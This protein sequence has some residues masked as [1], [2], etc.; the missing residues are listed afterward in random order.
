M[1]SRKKFS[2]GYFLAD[3]SDRGF[4]RGIDAGNQDAF[5]HLVVFDPA[6]SIM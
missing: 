2:I 6:F 3:F 5:L 4:N 1:E